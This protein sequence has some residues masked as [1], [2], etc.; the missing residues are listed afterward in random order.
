MI[1]FL[2]TSVAKT[3][4]N[5]GKL[6]CSRIG[7]EISIPSRNKFSKCAVTNFNGR[8]SQTYKPNFE[9]YARFHCSYLHYFQWPGCQSLAE[10]PAEIPACRWI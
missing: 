2:T 8:N 3:T 10:I 4:A 5:T 1:C 9:I 7:F 6:S